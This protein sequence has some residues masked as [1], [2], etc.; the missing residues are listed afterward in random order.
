MKVFICTFFMIIL[1]A[2]VPVWGQEERPGENLLQ[3][4]RI[5]PDFTEDIQDWQ[6]RLEL[7]RLLSYVE[8]YEQS[9]THYRKVLQEKPDLI[10][11]RLEL[12]RVYYWMDETDKAEELFASVPKDR[13]TG[14]ARLELAEIYAMRQEYDRAVEVYEAY[15]QEYPGE[16]RVRFRLARVLSWKGDY[17]SSISEYERV[18]ESRP[19]DN[20]VRRHYAQVLMWAERY[21]E[22][23]EELEK[24][25]GD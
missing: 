7:A 23:I 3:Q 12:A 4:E 13:L 16:A 14:E 10:E 20:Q 21:D 11:A 25:L 24:T 22:A 9:I 6:A 8:R 19:G 15:L 5:S 1:W 2:A 18:L 17:Q